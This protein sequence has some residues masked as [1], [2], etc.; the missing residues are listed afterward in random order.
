MLYEDSV[1]RGVKVA[2]SYDVKM[3]SFIVGVERFEYCTMKMEVMGS[4]ETMVPS[5]QS[6]WHRIPET[7]MLTSS[8]CG[9]GVGS[10]WLR[11]HLDGTVEFYLLT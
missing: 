2:V 3:S 4:T 10:L 5:F 11:C 9:F 1:I 6:A 7:I 8:G